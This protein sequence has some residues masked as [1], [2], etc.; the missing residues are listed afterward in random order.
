M[1]LGSCSYPRDKSSSIFLFSL[2][3]RPRIVLK[4]TWAFEPDGS[5]NRD[6]M[7]VDLN[8]ASRMD[9]ELLQAWQRIFIPNLSD[10]VIDLAAITTSNLFSAHEL[11]R[12]F[13][14]ASSRYDPFG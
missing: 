10:Y 3:T 13:G 11:L 14:R 8:L 6:G 9:Y 4:E 1:L 12:V 2:V 5:I 7:Q